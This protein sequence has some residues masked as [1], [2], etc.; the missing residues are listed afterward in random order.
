V[1]L[2]PSPAMGLTWPAV[3]T[4]ALWAAVAAI[5]VW[6][7]TWPL[8][9]RSGGGLLLS[10]TLTCTAA[11]AGAML[12]AVHSMLL[13]MGDE[14][15]VLV[16]VGLA[17]GLA[18]VPAVLAAR[19]L[20]REHVAVSRAV[21]ELSAGTA[22]DLSGP[23]LRGDLQRL[24]EQLHR[25]ATE[26]NESR[27][28]EQ[29]LEGARRELVAWVSHDLR[30]PLAGL[31]AL[32]EALEDGVASDPESYY[33]Q[34]SATVDRLSDLVE[35]LFDLS[36]VQAGALGR[37]VDPV[38]VLELADDTV[39]A[40]TPLAARTGVRLVA[41]V[42]ASVGDAR[43]GPVVSGN[44]AELARALTNVVANAIRYTDEDG[45]VEVNITTRPGEHAEIVV[46][47]QCGGIE[48]AVMER[49]F[50]VGFRGDSA[51][52]PNRGGAG[53]GLAITR[54]IVEAHRGSVSVANTATGCA[55]R[56]TLPL[57]SSRPDP[58]A[59]A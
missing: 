25:T 43:P 16:P 45:V 29:S 37:L 30:T 59:R 36:R 11:S 40:L 19:R 42:N 56:L 17:G 55:F 39:A 53:L 52:T 38:S 27:D 21:E 23:Q 51:R 31:R 26:L 9:R 49:L 2:L 24:R 4:A 1:S 46:A 10:T 33:K 35:D 22:P 12:G 58:R 48:P 6:L 5:A 32:A 20:G 18:A 14:T 44:A 54:G 47:D 41:T 57:Q 13:P 8:R 3:G 34:I 15:L 7:A 50:D 28:R